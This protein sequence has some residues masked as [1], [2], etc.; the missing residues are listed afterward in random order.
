MLVL[1]ELGEQSNRRRI[2]IFGTDLQERAL[3]HARVGDLFRS[4]GGGSFRRKAKAF[5]R[6]QRSRLSNSE[7]D[8][9]DL[10]VFAKH[11]L[12]RDPPFSRLDLVSCRNVLIYMGPAL[13][14]RIL[15]TFQYALKP[16]G[17]LFLGTS[18]SVSDYSDAFTAVD[19]KQRIFQ[20][21]PSA[22]A[23][24]EDSGRTG[25]DTRAIRPLPRAVALSAGAYGFPERGG[26]QR[27]C[28]T[29]RRPR[30]WWIR[31]FTSCISRATPAPIWRH[32]RDSR[33]F[34]C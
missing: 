32:R 8:L 34:I 29:M 1:E 19:G 23:F 22:T 10:C 28:S 17:F 6:A 5:F 20:R 2:Q 24:R 7:S 30:W 3:E 11:D 16:G 26:R 25:T 13:Q 9:A 31:I 21:K 14:K 15:S 12:T 18:E 4:G 27:C 33:A